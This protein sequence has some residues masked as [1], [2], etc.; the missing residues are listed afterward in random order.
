MARLAEMVEG[1]GS[2]SGGLYREHGSLT[3]D[4]H[5]G[6]QQVP[7]K[8]IMSVVQLRTLCDTE[9]T[10]LEPWIH[11]SVSQVN[12]KRTRHTKAVPLARVMV[13]QFSM[14]ACHVT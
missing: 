12:G 13:S 1:P 6:S 8:S 11:K 10:V 3:Q 14:Q 5:G 7:V 2:G 4:G 9:K